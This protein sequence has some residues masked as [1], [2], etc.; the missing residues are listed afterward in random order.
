LNT[1]GTQHAAYRLGTA[2]F[3]LCNA[4]RSIP[5]AYR[6]VSFDIPGGDFVALIG[7]SDCGK[8]SLVKIVAGL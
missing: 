7:P 8:T 3:R 5:F 2:I 4:F 1:T 6:D